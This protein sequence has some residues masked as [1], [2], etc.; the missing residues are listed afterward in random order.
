[1]KHQRRLLA[2]G[3]IVVLTLLGSLMRAGQL[4][5]I[6]DA[7]GLPAAGH[8]LSWMLAILTV[9]TVVL[10][11]LFV[12]LLPRS[13]TVSESCAVQLAVQALAGALV[14]I[15][16]AAGLFRQIRLQPASYHTALYFV[17]MLAGMCMIGIGW[18]QYK[19]QQPGAGYF[20]VISIWQLLTLLLN[21]RGWSMDPTILDYCFR[22]FALV[23]G[24]CAAY[25]LGA[26]G[27]EKKGRR[28][29]AFW[30]MTGSFFAVVSVF[31]E[32]AGWYLAEL[33]MGLWLLVNVWR[34]F[35]K[36]E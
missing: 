2:A 12:Q 21:F 28:M 20:A 13:G 23:S 16:A 7:A 24:M 17:Q 34:L 31:G 32:T 29:T 11:V 25:H 33:G 6:F 35:A 8:P 19:E 5:R 4:H 26:I 18:L 15:G 9:L 3:S 30:C 22:L 1:M 36:S 14:L 10:G 27:L